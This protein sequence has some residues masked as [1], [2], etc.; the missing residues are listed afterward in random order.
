MVEP[1]AYNRQVAGSIPAMTTNFRGHA[2]ATRRSETDGSRAI[3][4]RL[5]SVAATPKND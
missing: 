4:N 3:I 5:G 2:M 1:A